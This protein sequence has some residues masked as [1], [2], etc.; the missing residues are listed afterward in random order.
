MKTDNVIRKEVRAIV[1]KYDVELVSLTRNIKMS[2]DI[3][4]DHPIYYKENDKMEDEIRGIKGV[5]INDI[6]HLEV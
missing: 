4:L 6:C 2:V 3:Q 1:G 5:V